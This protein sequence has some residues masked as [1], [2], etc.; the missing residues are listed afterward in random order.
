MSDRTAVERA[1]LTDAAEGGR[2]VVFAES[3]RTVQL[4]LD[5][6]ESIPGH[7]HPDTDVVFYLRSGRLDLRLG[8]ETHSL[9][10]GDV[11]RFD[12]DQE[13]APT[14][15]EDSTALVILV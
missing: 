14:A 7:R 1:S 6:D 9:S 11:V 8:E 5:A 3:P 13:I 10:G 2:S 4:S 15:L 12:G